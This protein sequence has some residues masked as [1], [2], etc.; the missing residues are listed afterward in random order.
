M[1][2]S[3]IDSFSSSKNKT[4]NFERTPKNANLDN[5]KPN[6]SKTKLAVLGTLATGLAIG[7]AVLYNWKKGKGATLPANNSDALSPS[8]LSSKI[9]N[10]IKNLQGDVLDRTT[11]IKNIF[12]K[13]M[14]YSEDTVKIVEKIAGNG[15]AGFCP[16]QCNIAVDIN[17]F[18]QKTNGEI[19]GIIRHELD[20]MDKQVKL[21]KFMGIEKYKEFVVER[22]KG[23]PEFIDFVNKS[24]NSDFYEKA[25]KN[26]NIDNFDFDLYYNALL[27]H[28]NP[29]LADFSDY[30]VYFNYSKYRNNAFEK[31]AFSVQREVEKA[32][33]INAKTNDIIEQVFPK[34]DRQ[35]D[36]CVKSY[37]CIK[38]DKSMIF[39][40]FLEKA[41]IEC[42]A[43]VKTAYGK[44]LSNSN[45]IE[46]KEKYVQ[47]LLDRKN[48]LGVGEGICKNQELLVKVFDKIGEMSKKPFSVDEIKEIFGRRYTTLQFYCQNGFSKEASSLFEKLQKNYSDFLR[49]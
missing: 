29:K 30:S 46:F 5:V 4:I 44:M 38:F 7:A 17:V 48:K 45:N 26:V 2:I 11:Q 10:K 6:N 9:V 41:I 3:A 20:H 19:A 35:L 36:E 39:D 42:D 27:E 37:P 21:C 16:L 24:F 23:T 40:C 49:M 43:T 13:E 34:L 33:G 25:M 31:S 15:E 14:G 32:F 28:Y 22:Y 18:S 12:M 1:N 8:I 47:L